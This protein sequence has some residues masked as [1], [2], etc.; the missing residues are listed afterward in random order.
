ML[1]TKIK[2]ED[3]NELPQIDVEEITFFSYEHYWDGPLSGML[4]WNHQ[5]YYFN[6]VSHNAADWYKRVYVIFSLS[7][8]SFEDWKIRHQLWK[9]CSGNY[10][11][12][13]PEGY[14][15]IRP[16]ADFYNAY[17]AFV[18]KNLIG[19]PIASFQK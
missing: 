2:D 1:I 16:L 10:C 12:D 9:E 6:T 17:P 15:P 14:K 19:V 11:F 7:K 5:L 18:D 4:I 13:L 8:D 3:W